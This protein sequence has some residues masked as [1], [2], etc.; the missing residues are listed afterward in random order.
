MQNPI[1]VL[2]ILRRTF[3]SC[4]GRKRRRPLKIGIHSD[5]AETLG[6]LVTPD[7]IEAAL[8]RYTRAQS[9]LK[10][11]RTGAPRIDLLGRAAGEVS[12]EQAKIA[13]WQRS[14][15]RWGARQ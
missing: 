5:V 7:E 2:G 11:L 3:P 4:F 12:A 8:A 6:T 10:C 9:Y 1:Q 14:Q 15:A 13:E